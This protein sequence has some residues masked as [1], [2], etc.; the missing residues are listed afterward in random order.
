MYCV[1]YI[2]KDWYDNILLCRR[3]AAF[4]RLCFFTIDEIKDWAFKTL[5]GHGY[6]VEILDLNTGEN[7]HL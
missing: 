1:S 3:E 7:V 6:I 4:T 5:T 2:I